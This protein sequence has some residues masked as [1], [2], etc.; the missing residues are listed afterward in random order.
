MGRRDFLKLTIPSDISYL[1][2]IQGCVREAATKYG[3]TGVDLRQIELVLEEAV[4]NVVEH[5]YESAES[6]TFDIICEH[7]PGGLRIIIKEKGIPFDPRRVAAYNPDACMDERSERGM[8]IFLMKELMDEVEFLNLGA[9]GKETR[10]VKY[11]EGGKTAAE[12]AELFSVQEF[13]GSAPAVIKEKIP[14]TVRLMEPDEAIEISRCAYKSHGY[15][16]FEDHIYYPEVIIEMNRNGRMISAVAV[17]EDNRFM[18]HAALLYPY[19]G[20]RTAELTFIF[21]NEEYRGQGCMKRLCDFLYNVPKQ[22]RLCGIYTY[23]VTNHV[24]TQRVMVGMGINDCGIQLATSPATW[25]FKGIPG[26]NL[27]RISVVLS[28]K[29]LEDPEP[30]ILYAPA[31]HRGMIEKLYANIHARHHFAV[32]ETREPALAEEGSILET[33]IVESEGNA[34]ITVV[35]YGRDIMREIKR[36]VRELCLDQMAAIEL[37]LNLEDPAT[38]FLVSEFEK[39]DFFFSGIMPRESTGDCL[40]LQYLNNVPF[41]YDRVMVHTDMAGEILAYIRAHDPNASL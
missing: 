2:I 26:E 3:F 14:Y 6:D 15:T 12:D 33:D 29:Y 21:V 38:F 10:L 41:D 17:T 5:A 36:T 11:L 24:F 40:V 7:I 1:G 39:M 19:P 18:G 4:T 8:G 37:F 23:A 27:Q 9:E 31:H 22:H 34:G 25:K 16:F 28:F 32:P 13:P 35:R 20:A 30:L